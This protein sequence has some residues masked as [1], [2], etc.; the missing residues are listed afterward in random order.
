MINFQSIAKQMDCK[1][2]KL[3]KNYQIMNL[4]LEDKLPLRKK[5]KLRKLHRF[6][7]YLPAAFSLFP[8]CFP[9]DML[10]SESEL[11]I[12]TNEKSVDVFTL[13]FFLPLN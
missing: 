8:I 3:V 6:F 7:N 13:I 10:H 11:F 4:T 2:K 5:A 12:L 9:E 1:K